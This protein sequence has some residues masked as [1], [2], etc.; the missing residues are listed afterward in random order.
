MTFLI[1]LTML[2]FQIFFSRVDYHQLNLISSD[3]KKRQEFLKQYAKENS[4]DTPGKESLLLR[5]PKHITA[6]SSRISNDAEYVNYAARIVIAN[7]SDGR[8]NT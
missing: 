3:S 2:L 4:S 6:I 1:R 7:Y 5:S 8:R